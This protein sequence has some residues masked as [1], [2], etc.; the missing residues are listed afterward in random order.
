MTRDDATPE[1]PSAEKD[2]LEPERSGTDP[3][4]DEE[5]VHAD[6]RHPVSWLPTLVETVVAIV[7]ALVIGAVLVVFLGLTIFALDTAFKNAAFRAVEDRL[8][9]QVLA[10]ISAARP[11]ERTA[12]HG[13]VAGTG[14]RRRYCRDA[15][16]S[17]T[18]RGLHL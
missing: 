6:L 17:R 2:P 9:V 3:K 12:S 18:R 14:R 15:R 1:P 13:R 11:H 10:L 7:V 8:Q 4:P 16:S 5:V